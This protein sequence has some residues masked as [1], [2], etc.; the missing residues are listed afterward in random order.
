LITGKCPA[1]KHPAVGEKKEGGFYGHTVALVPYDLDS[2]GVLDLAVANL[3][4]PDD[5]GSLTDEAHVLVDGSQRREAMP[6]FLE[7]PFGFGTVDR[8]LGLHAAGW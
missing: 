7:A 4:H 3:W 1:P 2:R 8:M 6:Y 5:R